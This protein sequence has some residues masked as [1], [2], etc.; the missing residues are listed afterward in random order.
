[1]KIIVVII[2]VIISNANLETLERRGKGL[3]DCL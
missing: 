3:L 1:V 2:I